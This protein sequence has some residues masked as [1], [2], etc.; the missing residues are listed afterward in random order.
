MN[1][2]PQV[3]IV[4]PA[5]NVA[6]YIGATLKAVFAQTFTDFEVVIVND[7]SPDTPE[8]ERALE[9]FM[10]RIRYFVQEN[11]GAGPARNTALRAARGEFVA[12]LDADDLWLPTYLAEQVRFMQG[13][14]YDLIYCDALLVGD[15]DIAGKT[16]MQTSP[17]NGPVTFKSLVHYTCNL[18][19]SG[20]MARRRLVLDAGLFDETLRNGQD[21]ELWL[22]LV[23][24]G[25]RVAYQRKVLL[26]YLCR[27]DSLSFTDAVT[28]IVRQQRIFNRILEKY[29][30]TPEEHTEIDQM[31][32]QLDAEMDF[33]LG[34][35]NFAKGNFSE[36]SRRLKKANVF[37][38]SFKV[39][40]IILLIS[41]APRLMQ[42]VYFRFLG[43][44]INFKETQGELVV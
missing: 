40:A 2:N 7:G 15:S 27:S 26:H 41:I 21:F 24:N 12:F 29:D 4:I 38:K 30:L 11:R 19:T 31:L 36:A 33:E 9:P 20:T 43:R 6:A 22:R 28:K 35:V 23:R 44:K 16:Y 42:Q 5:Y 32:E 13:G 1:S 18:V 8:L 25:A 14:N 34:K 37:Q 39:K 10:D 17:S 3:S